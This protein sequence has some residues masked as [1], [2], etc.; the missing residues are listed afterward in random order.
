MQTEV[1]LSPDG[2]LVA[3]VSDISGSLELWT[4]PSG[5]GW[6]TQLTGLG[7]YVRGIQFSKDGKW[8]YF[9]SDFGGDDRPDLYRVP[10]AGGRVENLTHSKRAEMSAVLSYDGTK[11]AFRGDPRVPFLFELFVKDLKTGREKKLT[12]EPVNIHSPVWSRSGDRIAVT[13]SG[14]DQQ[15]EL[16]VI[17]IATGK[18]WEIPSPTDGGILFP[19]AFSPDDKTI[20]LTAQNPRG[21]MQLATVSPDEGVVRFV[22]PAGWD[23]DSAVWHKRRGIFFTRNEEGRTGLYRMRSPKAKH[24][25]V[26]AAEGVI[27]SYDLDASGESMIFLQESSQRPA[28]AWLMHVRSRRKTQVTHS[29]VGGVAPETMSPS[30]IIHYKSPDGTMISGLLI[31]P[32]V[33]RLGTP[34]PV[35]AHIHGGPDYQAF[36]DFY[37]IRQALAEAGFAVF[38]PNYRG[39]AGFGRKFLDLNNKDWGG[40]DLKDI[41]AGVEYLAA[42]GKVDKDR[43]GITGGSYGGFMTLT[44]LTK[45]PKVW[46]AGIESYGMA[47]LPLDYKMGG[48]QFFDWYHTEMGSPKTHPKL[49]R[50]RS[51]INYLSRIK[52]PLMIFQGE[53]DTNVPVSQSRRIHKALKKRGIPVE[54]VIYPDEGHG[55]TKR[56]NRLD[57]MNRSVKFFREHLGRKK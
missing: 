22:G 53:N 15:G 49:F 35:I 56:K 1:A 21:F 37:P 26:V 51:P 30:K 42:Q 36:D 38:A 41:I 31:E 28:D 9:G 29:V 2:S 55:F 33:H 3:F 44:A 43:A 39:S 6:P 54:I 5:S 52:A 20:L 12:N 46:K 27:N 34:P 13:R 19:A 40:G 18:V 48:K 17:E 23:V 16:L 25:E 4:V 10:A 7:A 8:I 45:S 50:E 24:H 32:K 47:D 14:D 11:L 57:Y